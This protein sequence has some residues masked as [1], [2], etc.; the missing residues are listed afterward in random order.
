MKREIL[1][2]HYLLQQDRNSM[3]F[4]VLKATRDNLANNDFVKTCQQYLDKLN[5]QFNFEQL[6]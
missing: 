1:F 5:I 6:G 4:Q 3:I 2:L